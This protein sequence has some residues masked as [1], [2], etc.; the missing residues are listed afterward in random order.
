MAGSSG[1]PLFW[2]VF[3]SFWVGF[4]DLPSLGVLSFFGGSC[5][6]VKRWCLWFV[7]VSSFL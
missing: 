3:G 4:F 1:L 5:D 2:F 6:V 7:V